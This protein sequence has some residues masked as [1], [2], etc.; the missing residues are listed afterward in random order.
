[1]GG[2]CNHLPSPVHQRGVEDIRPQAAGRWDPIRHPCRR[3][4][5]SLLG[6]FDKGLLINQFPD[7]PA[8]ALTLP[9]AL[10]DEQR[11]ALTFIAVIITYCCGS[12]QLASMLDQVTS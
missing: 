9:V 3:R 1:M 2:G 6:H 11:K 5:H 10:V 8:V 4:S 12:G 7:V